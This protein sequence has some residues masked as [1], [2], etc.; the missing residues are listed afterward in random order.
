MKEFFIP[1]KGKGNIH[2][3]KWEP[4]GEIKGIIQIV[5]GI[6]EYVAR[7]DALAKHLADNGF[8]V[9]GEDHMG[10]GGS[11]SDDTVR[12]YFYGG[13]CTAVDDTYSLLEKTKKEYPNKP[14]FIYGHSMGSF[15][16]RTL[17]YRY[18]DA[19]LAGVLISGTGWQ[20][21]LILNLGISICKMQAKK[22]GNTGVSEVVKKLMFGSYNKAYDN[23]RTEY[24]WL[25]K[26]PMV[27]DKYIE[28]P[29]CGFDPTVGLAMAMLSGMKMN[30]DDK[31]LQCMPK[32]L[33]VLIFSGD[34]DP[35]GGNGK[36]VKQT[37]HAFEKAGMNEVSIKLYP[38]GRHE[39]H[40]ETN[41]EEVYG[42]ILS[43]LTKHS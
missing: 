10:H 27:I 6:A 37:F 15:M 16:T 5:H 31:N 38:Q 9:V 32:Q 28:D 42:D 2:C 36:G 30:Q 8:V 14:Y 33:P 24:D 13:W 29:L 4:K 12:G 19:G 20:P 26:D 40:N 39:M 35:V 22:L 23:P 18:P 43:F 7:Y 3:C 1:S 25:S 11:I 41:R 34:M 21:K 17:L